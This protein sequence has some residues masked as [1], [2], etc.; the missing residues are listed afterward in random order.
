MDL[1]LFSA[2]DASSTP[3]ILLPPATV[4]PPDIMVLVGEARVGDVEDGDRFSSTS[5]DSL[6][7]NASFEN[8]RIAS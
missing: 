6:R 2:V 1:L 8:R 5:G 4:V 3:L 7:F